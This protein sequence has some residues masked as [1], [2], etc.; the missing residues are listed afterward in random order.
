MGRHTHR[1]LD[2]TRGPTRALGEQDL[3]RGGD[4]EAQGKLGQGKQG[5]DRKGHEL[6]L[7]F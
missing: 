6:K 2:G 4:V 5:L 1:K 3:A 7:M